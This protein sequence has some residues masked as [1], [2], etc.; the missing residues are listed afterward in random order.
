[1]GRTM[2]VLPCN[3]MHFME[4]NGT[5]TLTEIRFMPPD[6]Q[7]TFKRFSPHAK[8]AVLLKVCYKLFA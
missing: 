5:V 4:K 8:P 3:V 6:A 2:A 1:M 7:I